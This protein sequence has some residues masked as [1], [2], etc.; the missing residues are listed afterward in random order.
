MS[1]INYKELASK[2]LKMRARS[3]T[4]YSHY[5]VGAAIATPDGKIY[6][7]CNAENAAYSPGICAERNAIYKAVSEGDKE[8]VAIAIAGGREGH[9]PTEYCP[10]C[11][12]CRQVIRE[13]C[14]LDTKILLVKSEDDYQ[15]YTLDQLLP[16]S[17]GPENL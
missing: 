10:P 11:G 13:F 15:E 4:P 7:G 1:D 12:V 16:Q 14:K 2:A 9:E 8:F 17:F 5:C 6:T 3:Y